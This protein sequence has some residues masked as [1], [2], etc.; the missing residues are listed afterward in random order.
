MGSAFSYVNSAPVER[1]KTPSA[2]HVTEEIKRYRLEAE[3]LKL[4]AK[5]RSARFFAKLVAR[6]T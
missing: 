3:A 1:Q 4:V 5:V 6:T 2:S